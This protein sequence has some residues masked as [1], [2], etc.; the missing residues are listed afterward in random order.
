MRT[1]DRPE[2]LTTQGESRRRL[3]LGASAVP[4]ALAA[5]GTL[6]S[7]Q[8]R[9]SLKTNARIV[10][11]GSGLAGLAVANRLARELDGAQIT[12]VDRKEE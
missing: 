4:L 7:P 9:A 2:N 5:G 3:L 8:A 6:S 11:V 10:I 1:P 12:V